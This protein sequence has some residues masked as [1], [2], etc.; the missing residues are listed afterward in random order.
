MQLMSSE[1]R[2]RVSSIALLYQRKGEVSIP[3]SFD[4]IRVQAG[5]GSR[6]EFPSLVRVSGFEP[7]TP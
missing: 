6:A 3:T 1:R 2:R 7:P 4:A 5:A